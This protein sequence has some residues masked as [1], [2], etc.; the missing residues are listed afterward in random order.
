MSNFMDIVLILFV[1]QI[2][3]PLK[4]EITAKTQPIKCK[5]ASS[6]QNIW[7]DILKGKIIVII[8]VDW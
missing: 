5:K 3:K 1:L 4:F 7:Y 6:S 8:Q 2:S